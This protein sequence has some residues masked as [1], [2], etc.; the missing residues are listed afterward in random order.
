MLTVPVAIGGGLLGLLL[1]DQNQSLFSQVGL[2]MLVGLAAKNGILIVEFIN[3]LRDEGM[4]Y[5]EAIVEASVLR[6][7]PVLMTTLTTVM[8][9]LPLV[10]GT[11]AGAETRLVVGVVILYG[12]ALSAVFT[13]LVVPLA[14]RAVSRRTG[15]PGD[16]S[17]RVDAA[18]E[19]A[20]G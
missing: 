8:G 4:A 12:V 19:T 20:L 13:L 5:D 15:S 18:L 17:R 3:Q 2:I 11:G 6:L 14:Y 1:T 9:S 16:T 10:F 7:R